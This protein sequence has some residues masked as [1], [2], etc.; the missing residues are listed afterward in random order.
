MVNLYSVF[1]L[2]PGA[3]SDAIKT[4]YYRLAKQYHPDTHAGETSQERI[5]EINQAYETLG[6]PVA[7]AAYDVMLVRERSETR[8]RSWK[9]VATGA[10]TFTLTLGL[11]PLLMSW[12]QQVPT[13]PSE[14]TQLAVFAPNEDPT[15]NEFA[16]SFN[17]GPSPATDF[18]QVNAS[19][20]FLFG[21]DMPELEVQPPHSIEPGSLELPLSQRT[22]I[23]RG[24]PAVREG[25]TNSKPSVESRRSRKRREY[26]VGRSGR[27]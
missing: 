6:D 21:L 18:V 14:I 5:R 10:S 3:S 27:T 12:T 20:D 16:E 15:V 11:F 22:I 1:G 24:G 19:G 23:G 9:A 7:R 2:S 25:R 8:R 17:V 13:S 26:I 4:A